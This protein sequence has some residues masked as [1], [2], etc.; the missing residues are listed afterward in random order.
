MNQDEK[1]HAVQCFIATL[2]GAMT[3]HS[4]AGREEETHLPP[5]QIA[6]LAVEQLPEELRDPDEVWEHY[7]EA[8]KKWLAERAEK[9]RKMRVLT[10]E[11]ERRELDEASAGAPE[12]AAPE[13]SKLPTAAELAEIIYA[14]RQECYNVRE[15][16]MQV[17]REEGNGHRDAFCD[18]HIVNS[19]NAAIECVDEMLRAAKK[20]LADEANKDADGAEIL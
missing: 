7:G 8:R 16:R 4:R 6:D 20:L 5:K 9:V 1:N 12:A 19:A 13:K 15:A 18:D 11:L 14:K 2:M 10:E 17:M 3:G